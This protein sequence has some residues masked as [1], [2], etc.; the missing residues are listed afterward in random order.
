M[1]WQTSPNITTLQNS[2]GLKP[3]QPTTKK[4]RQTLSQHNYCTSDYMKHE[5]R[6]VTKA[7]RVLEGNIVLKALKALKEHPDKV[8]PEAAV[9]CLTSRRFIPRH[10]ILKII[11]SP[12]HTV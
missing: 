6:T 5:T 2:N 9:F 7:G 4:R 11:H 10:M 12:S 8:Q 3:S 1:N